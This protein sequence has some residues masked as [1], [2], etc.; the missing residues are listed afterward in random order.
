MVAYTVR[1]LGCGHV[2]NKQLHIRPKLNQLSQ[3]DLI[4]IWED[5][6]FRQ[7]C[8]GNRLL[9]QPVSEAELDAQI[10]GEQPREFLHLAAVLAYLALGSHEALEGFCLPSSSD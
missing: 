3:H 10:A 7:L 9:R 4:Y 2:I 6:I 1:A 5:K 8:I